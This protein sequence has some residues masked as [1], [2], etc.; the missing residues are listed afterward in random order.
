MG[1]DEDNNNNDG[2]VHMNAIRLTAFIQTKEYEEKKFIESHG[3]VAL[4]KKES[5]RISKTALCV[6]CALCIP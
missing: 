6:C 3:K 1:N 5:A 2:F 4:G